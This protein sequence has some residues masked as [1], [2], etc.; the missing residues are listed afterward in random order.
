MQDRDII[1]RAL[2]RTEL[3]SQRVT[4]THV[5]LSLPHTGYH[6]SSMA[7]AGC[8]S[9]MACTESPSCS[10]TTIVPRA[11]RDLH[12]ARQRHG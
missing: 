3:L 8:S 7:A 10:F 9:V 1:T 2:P 12:A 4:D 6:S 5:H 11:E